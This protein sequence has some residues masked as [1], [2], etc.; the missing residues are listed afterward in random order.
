MDIDF[1]NVPQ[2]EAY[3]AALRAMRNPDFLKTP[4]YQEQLHRAKR[5]G[6][7]ER[8][9]EFSRKL[10]ARCGGLGIPMF[11]HTMVR[12]YDDQLSAVV[13]GVSNDWP[14]DGLWP[15]RF[16][17]VDIIHGKL[18]WMDKPAIPHAWDVIGHIGKEVAKSMNL[19]VTW[20]GDFKRLYDPAHWELTGWRE[21]LPPDERPHKPKKAGDLP[22][23][24]TVEK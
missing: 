23:G 5:E 12:T 22:V 2:R 16:A 10:I 11:V 9:V 1:R 14:N 17:A 7:D 24:M 19:D 15:H 3:P 4:K 20:G 18:G 13:R 8:I 6:A 21:M